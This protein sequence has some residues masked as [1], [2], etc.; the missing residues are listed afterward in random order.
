MNENFNQQE[1][2]QKKQEVYHRMLVIA[3]P[4]AFQ[5]I[6][7][8]AVNML[9]T[10]M[11]GSLG[12]V[13]MSAA[14]LAN[15]LFFILTMLVFGITGGSNVLVAQFWGLQD[16][17]AINKVLSYTYRIGI[18]SA[19]LLTLAGLLMPGQFLGVFTSD[20]QVIEAGIP[21]LR[22]LA[23]SYLFYTITTITTG[24]LRCV[25][26]LRISVILSAASLVINGVLNWILIFGK[27]GFP[28][29]GVTGAA[30][31]TV[32]ARLAEFVILIWFIWK[33]EDRLRLSLKNLKQLDRSFMGNYVRNT[34]PVVCNELFWSVGATVLAI[35]MGRMG[36]EVV[37][38]NSIHSVTSQLC[39]VMMQGVN[40]A[41]SVM[42]GNTIGAKLYQEI[43]I[44][45][46]QLRKTSVVVGF[47]A[48]GLVLLL[49]P[50]MISLYNVS[51]L[52]KSYA[53]QIMTA[54]AIIEIF[55]ATQTMNNMG[56]LR[57]AGD[58]RFV[59]I[60]D[61]VFLWGLAVPLGFM[62]GL[63]WH[64]PIVAVYCVL[65][66][67]Q[68]FKLITSSIRLRSDRWIKNVT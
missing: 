57:G 63:V 12:E 13:A 54:G 37:A 50:F 34:V 41:A 28:P 17:A 1:V 60:N 66:C 5:N 46:A 8:F 64:W 53:F 55:R 6:L 15:Q 36:T 47:A 16:K 10:V 26:V 23:L 29:M 67:E 30:I 11:L 49:R 24:T 58:A 42:I 14:S 48:A 33:R 56:I 3:V 38:A 35:I 2:K 22:I 45:K 27:L 31:A 4:I 62:A 32:I 19:L 40:A 52:T 43:P 59:M 68:F 9:D 20:Q 25:H 44:L 65:Q 21:Y 18:C 51:D 39:G 61:L 7:N